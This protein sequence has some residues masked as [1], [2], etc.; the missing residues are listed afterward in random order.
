[1]RSHIDPAPC[2]DGAKCPLSRG[3]RMAFRSTLDCPTCALAHM[4]RE[5]D[6]AFA[7]LR[8]MSTLGEAGGRGAEVRRRLAVTA[9]ELG[10]VVR[11]A[12]RARRAMGRARP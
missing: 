5:A 11:S 1:M 9:D 10:D 4:D 6:D 8:V 2:V 3:R 12:E 7:R